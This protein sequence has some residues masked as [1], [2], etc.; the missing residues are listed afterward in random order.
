M[1][2]TDSC[3]LCGGMKMTRTEKALLAL[4]MSRRGS[5]GGQARAAAL[6]PERRRA[7]ARKAARARWGKR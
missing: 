3:R 7:I 4:V 6:S 1:S 2:S 5:I